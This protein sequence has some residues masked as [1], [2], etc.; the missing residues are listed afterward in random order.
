MINPAYKSAFLEGIKQKNK[1]ILDRDSHA[2]LRET[3]TD[4]LDNANQTAAFDY[5]GST[6]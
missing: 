2:L 4:L 6:R 1:E 5:L 3:S